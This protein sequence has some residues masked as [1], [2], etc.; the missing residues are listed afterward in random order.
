MPKRIV[1]AGLLVIFAIV[2]IGVVPEMIQ[3]QVTNV[4]TT[5]GGDRDKTIQSVVCP[6]CWPNPPNP[7]SC[8]GLVADSGGFCNLSLHP[9]SRPNNTQ[10]S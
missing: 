3:T 2:V 7:Q 10:L 1:A 9:I 4:H 5:V 6:Q 8:S